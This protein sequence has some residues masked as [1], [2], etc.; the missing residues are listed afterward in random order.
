MKNKIARACLVT[1]LFL[2]LLSIFLL[3]AAGGTASLFSIMT[4][5]AI[6]PAV[7]ETKK[8]RLLGLGALAVGIGLTDWDYHEGNQLR[9]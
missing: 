9:S 6:P 8:Q 2:L 3:S 5:F 7:L 1:Y 4:V